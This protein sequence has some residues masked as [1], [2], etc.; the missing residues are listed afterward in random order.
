MLMWTQYES[1]CY[2]LDVDNVKKERNLQRRA[3]QELTLKAE[4]VF[5][6]Q[7]EKEKEKKRVNRK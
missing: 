3:R 5:L 4:T 1:G 6:Y 2:C 7:M